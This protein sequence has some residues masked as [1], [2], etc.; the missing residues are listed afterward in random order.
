MFKFFT[1]LNKHQKSHR[2][3]QKDG[4]LVWLVGIQGNKVKADNC[5]AQS[6]IGCR[7]LLTNTDT[8]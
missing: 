7:D 1:K 3:A 4:M 8:S 5:S 6:A 2:G